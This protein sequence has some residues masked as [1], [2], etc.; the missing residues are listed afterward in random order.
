MNG[1]R[2]GVH[3][4]FSHIFLKQINNDD[5][6]FIVNS[7]FEHVSLELH[8]C[9]NFTWRVSYVDDT[10]FGGGLHFFFLCETQN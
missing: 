5:I 9:K 3:F 4:L 2:N 8:N 7:I 6:H 1:V 10:N